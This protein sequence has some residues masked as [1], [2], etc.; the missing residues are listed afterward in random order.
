MKKSQSSVVARNRKARFNYFVQDTVE[1]GLVLNGGEVKS[2]RGGKSS[3]EEAYAAEV[4][5]EFFLLNSYIPKYGNTFTR[6]YDDRR[7]RKILL[8][9]KEMIKLINSIAREGITV[10]PLSLYFNIR[11]YAKVELGVAKGKRKHEKRAAIKER[12]WKRE[13]S[14]LLKER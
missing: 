9:K 5:G 10:I 4:S 6:E 1:A 13:K 11:G 2:L 3:I 8:H 12:E 14:R 7:P